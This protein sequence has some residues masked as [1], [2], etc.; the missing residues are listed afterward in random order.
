[1]SYP[2]PTTLTPIGIMR[3]GLKSREDTPK[4]FDISTETG[5]LEI[6]PEYQEAMGEIKPGQTRH[7]E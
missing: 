2:D 1:M 6:F 7:D 4:N 5:T 3:C